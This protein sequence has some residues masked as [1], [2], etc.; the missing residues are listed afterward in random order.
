MSSYTIALLSD[1]RAGHTG[2]M[3]QPLRSVL[4][5][6]LPFANFACPENSLLHYSIH[7]TLYM[8]SRAERNPNYVLPGSSYCVASHDLSTNGFV[9]GA[10]QSKPSLVSLPQS[11]P[12]H[13]PNTAA[14]LHEAMQNI[15][16]MKDSNPLSSKDHVE[17]DVICGGPKSHGIHEEGREIEDSSDASSNSDKKRKSWKIMLSAE[18][19]VEIYKQL[20]SDTL[21]VTSKS[22]SVG[23]Q[24]GV[25]AKTIRD[26]WKRETWVKA[27]RK[28]WSEDDE[29]RYREK[30]RQEQDAE[31]CPPGSVASL[32]S[33]DMKR[34]SSPNSNS[35]CSRTRGRPK[36][37][38]DSRPRKRRFIMDSSDNA[39]D[40]PRA[41][42]IPCQNLAQNFSS[43]IPIKGFNQPYLHLTKCRS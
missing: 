8:R 34:T 36:G 38:K 22:V 10:S 24:F 12:M 11:Y 32:L 21:H 26:I 18:Q 41:A 31:R 17:Q 2:V 28:F 15:K 3:S 5:L 16:G 40:K 39:S 13:L 33:D 20:P 35:S 29:L 27:T 42:S 14:D 43:L 6:P 1:K 25:S 7:Q 4:P 37:V 30:E 9:L 23:K 19:A